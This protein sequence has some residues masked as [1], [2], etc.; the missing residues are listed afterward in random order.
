M[1]GDGDGL[2]WWQTRWFVLAAILASG[3]P[4]LWPALPP[5]VDMPGHLGL[6]RIMA[7][8]GQPPLAR[9]YAVHWAPIGNLGVEGLVLALHPLLDVEPASHLV[10][11]LIPPVTVAAMLWLA[12]EAHGR[13]PPAAPFALPLAFALPFQLG[14]VNFALAAA[15]ALAGLALWIRLA[16]RSRPW[17]RILLFVPIAGLVWLCHSFGWA[18]LGLFAFG[19]EWAMRRERGEP[20]GGAALRAALCCAPMA[21]PQLLAATGGVGLAGDTGDWFHLA[22]KAQWIA[23]LLRERWKAYDVACVILL[24]LLL[25]T[26]LRSK[27]LSFAPVLGVPALLGLVAFLLLPRLYAGGAY[28][29]MRIL[30]GTVAVA[31]L[32]IRVAPGE[33]ALANRLALAGSGFFAL[34]IITSIAAF[35]LFARGQ[36]AELGGLPLIPAG[37]A[38]L[39]LVDEPSTA[40]W[41]NPRLAHLDGIAIARRRV[42]TNGQWAIAGQQLIEPLHPGAAP[43][44]RDPSQLVRRPDAPW[45]QT[46]FDQAIAGFD[47]ATFSYVWTIG[48]PAGRAR[49]ADLA[50]V[51]SNGRSALYRVVRP[52]KARLSSATVPR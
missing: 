16:R 39:V 21:W 33:A 45:R 38:L 26:A 20:R 24:A 47:R 2:P 5:L 6:Y 46:G 23:A 19:A 36:Q 18:M 37:A 50:P 14:F 51:W 48:F 22:A 27:R 4:L 31:L 29:D 40:A 13:L 43:L 9:H 7:E 32:A 8:A 28:V 49:A 42:F 52:S 35:A 1:Q 30:P 34:R 15:L 11:G 12:R 17:V 10:V 25:W 44:D 3:L 41:E